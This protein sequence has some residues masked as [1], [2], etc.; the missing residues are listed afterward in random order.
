MSKSDLFMKAMQA[1]GAKPPF[2]GDAEEP[3]SVEPTSEGEDTDVSPD[4]KLAAYEVQEAIKGSGPE[5]AARLAKALK[6]FFLL[7]DAQPHTEGG[8]MDEGEE[9]PFPSAG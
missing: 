8:G 5:G 3:E 7:V 6:A 2:G 9:S 1:G 4:E